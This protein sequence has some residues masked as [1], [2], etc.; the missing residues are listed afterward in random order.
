MEPIIGAIIKVGF[1]WAP[2]GWQLCDGSLLSIANNS[3]LFSL[4][5]TTYGGDGVSTFAVPDLRS[6]IPIGQ[7]QGPG[8]QNYTMGQQVGVENVTLT[9]AELPPHSHLANMPASASNAS[10]TAPGGNASYALAAD[11]AREAVNMFGATDGSSMNV[12]VTGTGSSQPHDNIM[13]FGV[14]NYI[15]ATEGVFPSRQ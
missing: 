14:V 1:N 2:Q 7:G 15:I 6:R 11:P 12:S 8:L 5:G 4:L 13:P 10:A 3:A 9:G